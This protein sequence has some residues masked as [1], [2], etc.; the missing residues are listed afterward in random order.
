MINVSLPLG[1][2][3]YS[4]VSIKIQYQFSTL[5]PNDKSFGLYMPINISTT[6]SQTMI[7][8]NISV[9]QDGSRCSAIESE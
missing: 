5:F 9:P 3:T 8:W 4:L 1:F 6:G 7:W 2:M